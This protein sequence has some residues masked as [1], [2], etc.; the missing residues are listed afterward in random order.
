[1]K[2]VNGQAVPEGLAL[3]QLEAMLRSKDMQ[4]FS[5]ACEAL[6]NMETAD[7]Y[8]LLKRQLQTTDLYRR[9]YV[10][11]VI[12][13]FP[14][15][16]ELTAELEAAMKSGTP[17]LVTTALEQL[18]AG[19]AWVSEEAILS[20]FE[21]NH[22]RLDGSFYSVLSRIQKSPDHCQRILELYSGSSNSSTKIALAEC[23]LA[24][25]DVRNYE[26]LYTLFRND[27]APHIRI[28]ACRL[29][30]DYQREDWLRSFYTD[31]DGHIR[32]LA[33]AR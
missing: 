24:F 29:A 25:A 18:R 17:F 1:M 32:K 8:E 33:C 27:P 14:Q 5:L 11:S 19:K 16:S 26:S 15:A 28:L 30:K 20:C 6:R 31:P 23:L 4:T 21:R 7:A 13:D 22:N 9:R 10:L 3:E 2:T 12:F